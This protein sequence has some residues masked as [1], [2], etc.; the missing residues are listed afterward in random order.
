MRTATITLTMDTRVARWGIRIAGFLA[1]VIGRDGALR[2]A[3]VAVNRGIRYRIGRGRWQP[4]TGI[5]L[6]FMEQDQGPVEDPIDDPNHQDPSPDLPAP[7]EGNEDQ[8]DM[9]DDPAEGVEP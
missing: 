7:L 4:L 2:L 9:P 1:P 5:R 8:D 3:Q 6:S